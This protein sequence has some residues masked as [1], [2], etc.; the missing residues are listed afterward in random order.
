MLI[1][2]KLS[3]LNDEYKSLSYKWKD[4]ISILEDSNFLF[5]VSQDNGVAYNVSIN[6]DSYLDS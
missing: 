2:S 5:L 1:T 4:N 6:P 3:N